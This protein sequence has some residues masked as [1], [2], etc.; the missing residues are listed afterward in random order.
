MRFHHP[1]YL[2]YFNG[3]AG[4]APEKIL[5]DSNYDWG[6]DLKL[7]AKRLHQLGVKEFSLAAVNGVGMSM[8]EF[9]DYL[10]TWYGLPTIKDVDLCSPSPGW[11]VVST[12]VEQT[13]SRLPDSRFYRGPR[14]VETL[15][16][17]N[18]SD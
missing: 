18:R 6:Q 3:F 10:E 12:T 2:A 9:D 14:W 4:K 8:P 7:L 11:N 17:G 15:V 13:F 1:D 5:V 16:R